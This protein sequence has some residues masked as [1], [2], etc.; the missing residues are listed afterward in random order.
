MQEDIKVIWLD[1]LIRA[2]FYALI[3]FL[4]ISI[5]LVS[6]CSGFV[7][8]F[9]LV[10]RIVLVRKGKI[11]GFRAVI[12]VFRPTPSFLDWPVYSFIGAVVVSIVF[13]QFQALS[14]WSLFGKVLRGIYLYSSFLEAFTNV[15]QINNFVLIWIT[16]AF[17]TGVSGLSQYF[18]GIDFLRHTMLIGGR[19]SSSLRHS[20]DFGGY[21]VAI[22]PML[23]ILL[24]H[25]KNLNL[26]FQDKIRGR[27]GSKGFLWALFFITSIILVSCLGLTFSRGSWVA[28]FMA[29]I[30]AAFFKRK[31]VPVLLLLL[32]GFYLIFSPAMIKAR[33]VSFM[34]DD[35]STM[36][37]SAVNELNLEHY[38]I[39]SYMRSYLGNG[40]WG[41][42]NEALRII[43]D[44]PVWGAGLNTYSRMGPKYREAWGGYPHNSYLQMTAEIGLLGLG[45]FLWIIWALFAHIFSLIGGRLEGY[46]SVMSFGVLAG[47]LSYFVQS[48]FDT[49]F[50]SVQLS[51][52]MWLMIALAAAI[53]RLTK[54]EG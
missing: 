13:S 10:K 53:C 31:I 22:I 5:A 32:I 42:W 29:V 16:S 39:I 18:S 51:V 49:T 19:V 54:A 47:L 21:L 43:N 37:G 45:S 35:V 28:F 41:F 52:L 4:P 26:N 9:F 46:R 7:I 27:I 12:E 44:Y 15:R 3:F 50:Y 11:R 40:R 8:F 34:T 6:T 33:N 38:N 30:L 2:F 14:F 48:F 17:V 36:R 20:N 25:W 1:R 24:M 23:L